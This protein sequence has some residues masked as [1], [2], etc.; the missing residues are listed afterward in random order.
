MRSGTTI[1]STAFATE[2]EFEPSRSWSFPNGKPFSS[3]VCRS[4]PASAHLGAEPPLRIRIRGA[5]R[6]LRQPSAH[7]PIHPEVGPPCASPPAHPSVAGA[8]R[9]GDP[10]PRA[11][12]DTRARAGRLRAR[13]AAAGAGHERAH[14]GAPTDERAHA[15]PDS[16]ALAGLR[17]RNIGLNRGGPLAGGSGEPRAAA[18]VLVRSHR[19]RPVE[20]HRRRHHLQPMT[21]ASSASSN[22]RPSSYLV[23]FRNHAGRSRFE[24]S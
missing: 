16:L 5:L 13:D 20:D 22:P 9:V 24:R 17:W 12:R 18:G 1:C 7:L 8:L 14:A 6:S 19:R 21:S 4:S 11:P 10:R 2:P 3:G 23:I 15:N